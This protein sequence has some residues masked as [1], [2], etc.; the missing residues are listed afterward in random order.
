[1]RFTHLMFGL[2]LSVAA[3]TA[4]AS[5]ADI[6]ARQELM[7]ANGGATKAVAGMMKGQAPFDLATV[8][9]S[10]QTYIDNAD[11]FVT[12]FPEDS[13]T[14]A[15]TSASPKIWS[16]KAGFEAANAKFKN[17]ATAALASIKDEASFKDIMPGVLKNCGA[18][19]EAYRLKDD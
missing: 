5:T 1:M 19:H 10:L 6:G 15:K 4:I 7:K 13:K 16:D 9:K 14:G 3:G 2:A 17:D 12:L 18:C 8:K 11:K